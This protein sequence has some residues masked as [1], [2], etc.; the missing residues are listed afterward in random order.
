MP[1]S[2][3]LSSFPCYSACAKYGTRPSNCLHSGLEELPSV[4][5]LNAHYWVHIGVFKQIVEVNYSLSVCC[6]L[7]GTCV[8]GWSGYSPFLFK[9][10]SAPT[11]FSKLSRAGNAKDP[12]QKLAY[13]LAF[14]MLVDI[15]LV[16]HF[17][18]SAFWIKRAIVQLFWKRTVSTPYL[19]HVL[20]LITMNS[21]KFTFS[22]KMDTPPGFVVEK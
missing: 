11:V 12:I 2:I 22:Q 20:T 3:T 10:H 17:G 16:G 6:A 5:K 4:G 1:S 9:R 21:S 15:L 19:M 18:R 8:I 13:C 7:R 14:L